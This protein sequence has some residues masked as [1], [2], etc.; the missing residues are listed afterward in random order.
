M[1]IAST[2]TFVVLTFSCFL[3]DVF[4][5]ADNADEDVDAA[6]GAGAEE[7][8]AG[9]PV[10]LGSALTVKSLPCVSMIAEGNSANFVSRAV[11]RRDL[12]SA[13]SAL[14]VGLGEVVS[15]QSYYMRARIIPPKRLDIVSSGVRH[16]MG[17]R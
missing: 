15:D 7:D 4:P 10:R 3:T 9:V 16:T 17:N 8:G 11:V 1:N 14:T 2:V 6:A 12:A 13:K 5:E